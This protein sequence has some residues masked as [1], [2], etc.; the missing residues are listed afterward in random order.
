MQGHQGT[1]N[2]VMIQQGPASA[3]ILA[4]DQI[5]GLEHFDGAMAEI[6]QI[7]DGRGD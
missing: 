6:A 5:D 7:A 1:I 2:P 4:G 3:G